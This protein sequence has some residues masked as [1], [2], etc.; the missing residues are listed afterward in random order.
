VDEFSNQLAVKSLGG[1]LMQDVPF[2]LRPLA[3]RT[4]PASGTLTFA[5]LDD[6]F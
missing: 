6:S 2:P 1:S 5:V 3:L 4:T